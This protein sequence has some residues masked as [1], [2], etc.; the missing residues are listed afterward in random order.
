MITYNENIVKFIKTILENEKLD[1]KKL[2]VI[3]LG[4]NSGLLCTI[5]SKYFNKWIG[6]ETHNVFYNYLKSNINL[7]NCEFNKGF[8]EQIED[9]SVEL[10]ICNNVMKYNDENM[11]WYN[12]E[13]IMKKKGIIW[14]IDNEN[15]RR[16]CLK[17]KLWENVELYNIIKIKELNIM[18]LIT[19]YIYKKI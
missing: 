13:R 9:N 5:L 19:N 1:L 4:S 6:Y 10:L 16:K 11:M 7:Q 12:I 14:I 15:Y 8:I 18:N 17:K 3:E 2:D